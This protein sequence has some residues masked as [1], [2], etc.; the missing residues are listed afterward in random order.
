MH[1]APASLACALAVVLAAR[2][3]EAQD[4]PDAVRAAALFAEGRQLMAA[5]DY[6]AAC[7]KLAESQSLE[8]AADTALDLGICYQNAS[9][10]AFKV[11]HDL[12][13]STEGSGVVAPPAPA[14]L[15]DASSPATGQTQR[16]VGLVIGGAGV[17]GIVVGAIVGIAA[18]ARYDD[19]T[20]SCNGNVCPSATGVEELNSAM[21]MA[22]AATVSLVAGAAALAGGAIVFFTAPRPKTS[23]APTLGLGPAVQGAGLAVAGRF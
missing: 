2:V 23:S 12:A 6:A 21:S 8:P 22:R 14:A 1:P 4:T 3:A 17:A 10:A 19:V 15:P 13:R 5:G 20:R 11:A 9:Q 16:T 7:P 18:K